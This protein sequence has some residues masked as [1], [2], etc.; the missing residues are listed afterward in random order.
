MV[1]ETRLAGVELQKVRDEIAE[2]QA[3]RDSNMSQA[4]SAMESGDFDTAI[5]LGGVATRLDVEIEKLTV[6]LAKMDSEASAET[7]A[8]LAQEFQEFI[9]SCIEPRAG[10][11]MEF[12][13]QIWSLQPDTK[14]SSIVLGVDN[15][16][17]APLPTISLRGG[18]STGRTVAAGADR[19]PRLKWIDADGSELGRKAII[20]RYGAKYGQ[21]R[22]FS[23]MTP[24]ERETF[25]DRIIDAENL[26]VKGDEEDEEEDED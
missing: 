18:F 5:R 7:R 16:H 8:N 10:E 24:K 1:S 17:P 21:E 20:M 2:K 13:R 14:L 23:D 19:K 11:F 4:K 3:E 22:A 15:S 9:K 26:R 6:R 25:S 12:V